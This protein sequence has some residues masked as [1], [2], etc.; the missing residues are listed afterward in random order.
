[1]NASNK[2]DDD[3]NDPNR[4]ARLKQNLDEFISAEKNLLAGSD[5]AEGLEL[6]DKLDHFMHRLQQRMEPF[7]QGGESGSQ[8]TPSAQA[9]VTE[10]ET[11]RGL[12]TDEHLSHLEEAPGNAVASAEVLPQS[13]DEALSH[14]SHFEE[15][16]EAQS[17]DQGLYPEEKTENAVGDAVESAD[18]GVE[19]TAGASKVVDEEFGVNKSKELNDSD[20]PSQKSPYQ[21]AA[22]VTGAVVVA[23]LI[24]WVVWPSGEELPVAEKSSPEKSI[25]AKSIAEKAVVVKLIAEKPVVAKSIAEKPVVAQKV[26]KQEKTVPA[27][28]SEKEAVPD[29]GEKMTVIIATGNVREKPGASA[30]VLFKLR[31]GDVVT[32]LESKQGWHQ[33]V[34]S[35]GRKAWAY[36]SLFI[37]PKAQEKQPLEKAAAQADKTPA[38]KPAPVAEPAPAAQADKTPAEKPAPVAEPAPAVQADKTPA[39]KPAPIAEPAPA[40]TEVVPEAVE[41][42]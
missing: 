3:H 13:V 35:D 38:E 42:P 27:V 8:K 34:T 5:E 20:S 32:S 7:T 36:E 6:Q 1:M 21:R 10:T 31:K 28:V 2:N 39:E 15:E 12:L 30:K 25:A 24:V 14:L 22:Q 19:S 4:K 40:A 23:L 17:V 37:E 18:V 41:L 11:N 29:K 9:K 26:M 16:P 33:I